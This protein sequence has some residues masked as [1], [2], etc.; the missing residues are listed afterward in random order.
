MPITKDNET[1]PTT[2]VT[3]T[4]P[5]PAPAPNGTSPITTGDN[6]DFPNETVI[7]PNPSGGT[8]GG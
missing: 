1:K 7:P 6:S 3:T 4:Q 5:K 8:T 2:P